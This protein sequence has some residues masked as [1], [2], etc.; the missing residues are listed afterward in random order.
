[1]SKTDPFP[2]L[3]LKFSHF[4]DSPGGAPQVQQQRE[5]GRRALMKATM[6]TRAD[7]AKLA[8]AKRRQQCYD[9]P[10]IMSNSSPNVPP[11][12]IDDLDL[13]NSLDMFEGISPEEPDA[14]S[15]A[16]A[17]FALVGLNKGNV[18]HCHLDGPASEQPSLPQPSPLL[19]P[20]PPPAPPAPPAPP[21]I[22]AN[23][24][25]GPRGRG[26]GGK[27]GA[28]GGRGGGRQVVSGRGPGPR[29]MR[30]ARDRGRRARESQRIVE[31]KKTPLHNRS[32]DDK[33]SL[34][35][36]EKKLEKK[37]SADRRRLTLKDARCAD[38]ETTP[39]EER[40][41]EDKLFLEKTKKATE[42]KNEKKR[43]KYRQKKDENAALQLKFHDFF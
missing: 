6:P 32:D 3:P 42:Q 43:Q 17:A 24:G 35:A 30:N 21:G 15:A 36:F 11:E 23:R 19:P 27:V 34:E 13:D 25:Q 8:C 5:A 7:E 18:P 39:L 1:M 26:G 38:I 12:G 37:R 2:H 9:R 40:T 22:R 41:E 20:S 10:E 28:V 14:D 29:L 16:A 4:W 33:S 31:I